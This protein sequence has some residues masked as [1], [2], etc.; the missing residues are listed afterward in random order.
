MFDRNIRTALLSAVLL[1]T[2]L[3]LAANAGET[4]SVTVQSGD[5]NLASDAGRA[6]FQHRVT[7]AVTEVCGPTFGRTTEEV[8]A[9]ASCAK[10]AQASAA[11]Q[12]D[13]MVAAAKSGK[14]IAAGPAPSVR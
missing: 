12:M 2:A 1:L 9:Y 11:P 14:K 6:T 5:L 7:R 4:R 10:A 13:A 8:Q 3:P